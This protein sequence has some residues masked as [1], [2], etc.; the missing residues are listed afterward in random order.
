MLVIRLCMF[1]ERLYIKLMEL[2]VPIRT[3]KMRKK[4]LSS[5]III[6]IQKNEFIRT[7]KLLIVT[8]YT[9]NCI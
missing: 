8:N 9:E 3:E 5:K 4:F 1:I 6:T 2:K 7:E